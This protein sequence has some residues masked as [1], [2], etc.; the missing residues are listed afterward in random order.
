M[1][2]AKAELLDRIASGALA[3]LGTFK[4]IHGEEYYVTKDSSEYIL[5]GDETSWK[6]LQID[7]TI[8]CGD[9]HLSQD[10]A[11]NIFK[12]IDTEVTT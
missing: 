2:P 11:F 9:F 5:F 8:S 1:K 12:I 7:I 10:E 4:N 6:P 3:L